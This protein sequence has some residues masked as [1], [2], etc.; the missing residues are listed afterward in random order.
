[1]S[2][3]HEEDEDFRAEALGAGVVKRSRCD[4]RENSFRAQTLG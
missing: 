3:E 4:A 1:M 2:E